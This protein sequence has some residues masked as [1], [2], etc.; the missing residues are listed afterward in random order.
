MVWGAGT[1]INNSTIIFLSVLHFW[2]NGRR[3][4]LLQ[5]FGDDHNQVDTAF[6][7]N[8]DSINLMY[9]F[10]R[11]TKYLKFKVLGGPEPRWTSQGDEMW[12]TFC[13]Q[14]E[15]YRRELENISVCINQLE[16]GS[17][18]NVMFD[19]VGKRKVLPV[20]GMGKVNSISFAPLCPLF[21]GL[22]SSDCT[23]AIEFASYAGSNVDHTETFWNTLVEQD[24]VTGVEP[25]PAVWKKI[26]TAVG[27]SKCG[28]RQA[29]VEQV[30]C[31]KNRRNARADILVHGQDMFIIQNGV[32]LTKKWSCTEW[33]KLTD[34][35]E[36]LSI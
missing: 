25:T 11:A 7:W 18:S 1:I 27:N 33:K 22:A 12:P 17:L 32:V 30:F 28:Q 21:T 5:E 4:P 23:E 9:K 10:W 20:S 8:N 31:A 24:L 19:K 13:Q 6:Q 29:D 34:M 35:S 2:F 36:Q 14:H 3:P 16:T 26:T 15:D